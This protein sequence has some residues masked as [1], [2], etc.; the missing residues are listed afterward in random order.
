[1]PLHEFKCPC[2]HVTEDLFKVNEKPDFIPC[3]ECGE[4]A[5]SI[6]SMPAWMPP[7]FKGVQGNHGRYN[8]PA[9]GG[10]L[11]NTKEY[12]QA[13]EDRGLVR[14]DDV[15]HKAESIVSNGQ[16]TA[17]RHREEKVKLEVAKKKFQG[18]PEATALASAEVYN[19]DYLRK[20]QSEDITLTETI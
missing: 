17:Q 3:E 1:M 13:M 5:D 2:G 10:A 8:I 12:D 16:L 6:L 7:Q 20:R 18:N 14:Y 9:L 19:K 11:A 4:Q 15:Q